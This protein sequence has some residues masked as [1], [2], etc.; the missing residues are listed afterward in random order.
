MAPLLRIG[1]TG[2]IAS[3]KTTVSDRFAELG[4]PVIDAD[5]AAREVVKPGSR[6]LAQV[7]ERFGAGILTSDGQLNRAALRQRIF[8]H[9]TERHDLDAML[10]PL[11]RDFM[12]TRAAE[13]TGPYVILAI[14]LLVENPASRAGIDRILVVDTDEASQLQRLM[15]RDGSLERQAR[16]IL[17]AQASRADRLA[18]ADDVLHNDGSVAE[19]RQSVDRLH[20]RYLKLTSSRGSEPPSA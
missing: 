14:P 5:V 9:P 16:A 10:H 4:V 11:I 19:L 13:A 1:L 20:E 2:G 15:A 18:A 7:A 12:R 17:D 6:G 8:E 3:G